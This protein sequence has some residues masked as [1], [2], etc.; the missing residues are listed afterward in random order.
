MSGNARL[1]PTVDLGGKAVTRLIIGGNPFSGFSHITADRDAEMISYYTSQNILGAWQTAR[2]NGI[3]TIQTRGDRHQ[4]RL[5]T[6]YIQS[7]G[8]CQW[9]AQTASEMRDIIG[10]IKQIADTGPIAVY[11]HGTHTDSLWH[12]GKIDD[13]LEHVK[14][15]HD[16][17]L[18]AGVGTHMPEVIRYIEEEGWP[19]DFY[20]ASL[21]NLSK[22]EKKFVAEASDP[23]AKEVYEDADRE[24]MAETIRSVDKTCLA[25]KIFAAGRNTS[26]VEEVEAAIRYAYGNIKKKDAVVVG[27]F[28]RDRDEI[29]MNAELARKYCGGG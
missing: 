21:Y 6:E 29:A 18:P 23:Y 5:Y 19:V 11:N 13:V 22:T 1:L 20:M 7:G 9:I 3:N 24:A 8:E 17:G 12:H 16:A 28:Q 10:N 2:Q 26:T 15:I 25:F 14:A 4:R 27:V